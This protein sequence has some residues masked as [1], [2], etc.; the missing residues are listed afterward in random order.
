MSICQWAVYDCRQVCKRVWVC[1]SV[2]G[3]CMIV[4][5]CVSESGCVNLS[6]GCV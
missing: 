3:L 5:K 4:D 2:N 6:M 1:R